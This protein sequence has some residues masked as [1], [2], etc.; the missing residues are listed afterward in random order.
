M[1]FCIFVVSGVLA[2]EDKK[3]EIA[4]SAFAIPSR[5]PDIVITANTMTVKD[6]EAILEGNVRATRGPDILTC[7]RAIINNSE[8]FIIATLTPRLYRKEAIL[9]EKLTREATLDARTI[10]W[11]SKTGRFNASDSVNMKIDERTWDLATHSWVIISSDEMLGF[12]DKKHLIFSG[13]VKVRDK[14]HFGKGHRLDYYKDTSTAILS[15]DAYVKTKEWN[16]KKAKYEDKIIE[17]EK[18]TYNTKTKEAISE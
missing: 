13:N 12:R 18:I 1:L 14:D 15:G 3:L 9:K 5:P 17:G 2:V 16:K 4:S 7:N 6:G 10:F 11:N 8:K